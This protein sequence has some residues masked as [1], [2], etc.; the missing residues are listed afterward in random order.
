MREPIRPNPP[1]DRRR[2]VSRRRFLGV[3]GAAASLP[4]A[5]T[6]LGSC[7]VLQRKEAPKLGA[8]AEEI[9]KQRQLTPE[10]VTAA[11]MTYM[12]SGKYD[13]YLM[14]SSTGHGGQVLVHGL[15]SMRLLKVI[16]V[17]TP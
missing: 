12:P 14:F 13:E 15:P 9:I 10:D 16:A 11:L 8:S 6:L 17:F 7:N 1:S 2:K 3:L 5:G 4:T